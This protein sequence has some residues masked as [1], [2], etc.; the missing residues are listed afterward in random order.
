MIS[1]YGLHS[2]AAC[3]VWLHRE[4][5]GVRFKRG[6]TVIPA[7]LASVVATPRCTVLGA[8]GTRIALVEHL[9]AALH[10][11]G[12]WADVLIEVT[13]EE[14]PILDGSA[15]GWLDA[16]EALG[17][18]PSQPAGFSLNQP[19]IYQQNG[20]R[21]R[22]EPAPTSLSVE[23]A[24]DHPLIGKQQW[25]GAPR[26]YEQLLDARTFGFVAEVEALRAQGLATRAGLENVI[27]F[28]DTGSLNP[29][30]YAD[31]PV[32]HKALDALGDFFLLGQPLNAQLSVT[33][34]SHHA[35]VGFMKQL[36]P[37][38]TSTPPIPPKAPQV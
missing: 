8:K 13:G 5:G 28:S 38:L 19:L 30:R 11:R 33:R 3:K 20:T 18:P 24:Y 16:L 35:H 37:L 17:A 32:R 21:I 7:R 1:G 31:E 34:G 10:V 26:S 9:L 4:P 14:L 6:E 15:A 29:L 36:L 12:W 22:A 23:V 27:V 25:T 2:G